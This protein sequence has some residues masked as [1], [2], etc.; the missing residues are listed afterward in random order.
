VRIEEVL[1]EGIAKRELVIN[2]VPEARRLFMA[3]LSGLLLEQ[4]REPELPI[5]DESRAGAVLQAF[6]GGV[7]RRKQA[8]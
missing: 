1:R 3:L 8:S 7:A 6:L 4:A 2:D 5:L